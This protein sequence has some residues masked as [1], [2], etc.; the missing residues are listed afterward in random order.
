MPRTK[1]AEKPTKAPPKRAF[2]P[3]FPAIN[4]AEIASLS[5]YRLVKGQRNRITPELLEG[6]LEATSIMS[7][8]HLKPYGPGHLRVVARRADGA[9]LGDAYEL[10]LPDGEGHVPMHRDELERATATET[11]EVAI[12]E[13]A[14]AEQRVE[15]KRLMEEQRAQHTADMQTFSAI[16]DKVLDAQAR[17]APSASEVPSWVREELRDVKKELR[18][19]QAKLHETEKDFFKLQVKKTPTA[20]AE[21]D[22]SDPAALLAKYGPVINF[23]GKMLEEKNKPAEGAAAGAY[24]ATDANTVTING[25]TIPSPQML[26]GV[27]QTNGAT[28]ITD[29]LSDHAVASFRRLHTAGM[30]PP[31]YLELL[32]PV[33]S[34]G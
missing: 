22:L 7:D 25:E 23:F 3:L 16:I 24:P 6:P 17:T 21:L 2:H 12:Y 4:A 28:T 10:R 1:A 14:M 11:S 5:V 19:A 9:L 13:R 27:M 29:V 8:L 18:T 26:R 34:Q 33:L 20:S 31:A 32:G 15:F 30:L